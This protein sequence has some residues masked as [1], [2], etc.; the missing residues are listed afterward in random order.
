M[1]WLGM[2]GLGWEEHCRSRE[3]V[4][5]VLQSRGV[6]ICIYVC[7]YICICKRIYMYVCVYVYIHIFSCCISI[8]TT[9]NN[10]SSIRNKFWVSSLS[11]SYCSLCLFFSAMNPCIASYSLIHYC[12]I[13]FIRC[14]VRLRV[15]TSGIARDRQLCCGY[16]SSTRWM[17]SQMHN[18]INRENEICCDNKLYLSCLLSK[19]SIL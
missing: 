18:V 16:L 4:H 13:L 14:R 15:I 12:I 3:D 8:T 9:I 6:Y 2:A 17:I 5:V 7:V 1:G 19:F 10:I 11:F